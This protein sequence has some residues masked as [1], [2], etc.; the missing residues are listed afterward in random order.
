MTIHDG[1]L[2]HKD[3]SA[4]TG[5]SETT[6][7][8]YR[9]KFAE[10]IPLRSRGKPLRFAPVAA[11]VCKRIRH[12]FE[13]DLSV[14]EIRSLLQEEFPHLQAKGQS[15]GYGKTP[16]RGELS[17]ASA[18]LISETFQQCSAAWQ[19]QQQTLFKELIDTCSTLAE[20]QKETNVRLLKLQEAFADFL[21]L[22]LAREDTLGS[23]LERLNGQLK[24]HLESSDAGVHAL[25]EEI[26][27]GLAELRTALPLPAAEK[28][29]LVRNMYG[30]AT[31]Y[32]FQ[33]RDP[34]TEPPVFSDQ[35]DVPVRAP[36]AE[37]SAD[38]LSAP[39][40]VRSNTGDYLGIA[41][42]SERA[43][44]LNDFI[45]LLRKSYPEPQHFNLEWQ[46][47]PA[48]WLLQVVQA[49]VIRPIQYVLHMEPST[50]PKGNAV[51]VL[52]RL[53]RNG[54]EEPG[55]HLYTFIRRMR[56]MVAAASA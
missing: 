1:N 6:I 3:L 36:Q 54:R 21:S 35:P 47:R 14:A 48:G 32:V 23:G 12:C 55:P 18:S 16:D 37:P 33:G 29:V 4:V 40:V 11:D 8:S 19:Q 13:Q 9:R 17:E 28:S 50:T 5:V 46:E 51:V 42:R 25:A 20:A 52:Q 39:L 7:K 24:R 2:T 30:D 22:F 27:Q 41:G 26:G 43:F 38:F 53:E 45:K 34:K 10:F 56:A 15:K 49:E 31:R 44:C